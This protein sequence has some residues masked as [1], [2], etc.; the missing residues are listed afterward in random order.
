MTM[1]YTTLVKL[2]GTPTENCSDRQLAE[3][4]NRMVSVMDSGE[5]LVG[6]HIGDVAYRLIFP[7]A[8]PEHVYKIVGIKYD[9]WA[10]LQLTPTGQAWLDKHMIKVCK[11]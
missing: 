9:P 7:K 11:K 10:N 6:D 2:C 1:R 3:D 5:G 4:E 8:V